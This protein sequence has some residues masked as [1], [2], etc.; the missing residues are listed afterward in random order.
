VIKQRYSSLVTARTPE[1]VS[2]SR[3]QQTLF[4]I[5][6]II[7]FGSISA[8]IGGTRPVYSLPAYG[9]LG[10]LGIGGLFCL[11][12]NKPAPSQLCLISSLLF[13]GYV[14]IRVCF[15]P[16]V[17]LNREDGFLVLG[18]LVVYFSFA[19]A[20]TD[21]NRRFVFVFFLLALAMIQTVIGA[22]QFKDGNNFMLIPFL[23][24]FDYGSRASGFYVCPNH[25]SGFLEVVGLFGLGAV[26]WGRWQRW[27]RLC[28]AYLVGTCYL[29]LALTV[30]RA[31]YFSA[32]AGLLV[33]L[34]VSL[35][36]LFRAGTKKFWK[37]AVAAVVAAIAISVTVA[38]LA[39]KSFYLSTRAESAV[40]E[41]DNIRLDLWQAALQQIRLD[42]IWGTGSGTYLYYGRQFRSPRVQA[43]PIEAHNDY[44]QL[45]A[46]YGWAGV[47]GFLLFLLIHLFRVFKN[48]RRLGPRPGR[49]AGRFLSNRLALQVS[50]L[51]AIAAYMVHSAFD[52]NL[53]IPVN[54][55]LMAFVFGVIANPGLE[56]DEAAGWLGKGSLLVWRIALAAGGCFLIVQ[57]FRLLP[58]E[59]FAERSR[60]ALRDED[61]S[62]A[63]DYALRGLA[64]DHQNPNLYDYLG[65]A[66]I[67]EANQ[68]ED[69]EKRGSLLQQA[70]VAIEGAYVL[71]PRDVNYAVELALIY[72]A[73]NRFEEAESAFARAMELDPKSDTLKLDYQ[74]HL[75]RW[76]EAEDEDL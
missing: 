27:V 35:V 4:L 13:F 43:D 32:G 11:T 65:R 45:L 46:E 24:R 48:I 28:L 75:K 22:I 70:S 64:S 19:C 52:F 29:G 6:L 8:L 55:L 18:C 49:P 54:A 12:I 16:V 53:H 73:E 71:A 36:V 66:R 3:W 30:S 33:F 7:G 50:A 47:S 37:I 62:L 57:C 56:R 59:Y 67:V 51:A 72:D 44:L 25:L 42:P 61:I 5:L 39:N 10:L 23:Q 17:Y 2:A 69:Q 14:L 26:C 74:A 40:Q 1:P 63:A 34:A 21:T 76:R 60:I 15:S 41:T 20:F 58:A 9:F 31:G 38:F 68:T